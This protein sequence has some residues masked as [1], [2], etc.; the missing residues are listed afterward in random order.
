MIR[1]APPLKRR[2]TANLRCFYTNS[3]IAGPSFV[4]TGK[5]PALLT[6]I[7]RNGAQSGSII[8]P[9]ANLIQRENRRYMMRAGTRWLVM[10]V[11]ALT[12]FGLSKVVPA[13]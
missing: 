5:M 8:G 9:P 7:A 6:G 12:A 10:A 2:A 13:S 1:K 11:L 3:K 4:G